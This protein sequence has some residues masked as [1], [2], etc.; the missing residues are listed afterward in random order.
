MYLVQE[1][2]SE[3]NDLEETSKLGLK[4]R[5][6]WLPVDSVWGMQV[7]FQFTE[8]S[9][10]GFFVRIYSGPGLY[11]SGSN[12]FCDSEP[13]GG[14]TGKSLSITGCDTGKKG[15]ESN[16]EVWMVPGCTIHTFPAET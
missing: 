10:G 15:T 11:L 6:A 5:P 16:A 3:R 4:V 7:L 1:S 2:Q 12:S 14:V 8:H 13:I 9:A